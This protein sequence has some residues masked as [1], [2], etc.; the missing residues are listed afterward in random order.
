MRRERLAAAEDV[1]RYGKYI[2]PD[3]CDRT[4]VVRPMRRRYNGI[5][6]YSPTS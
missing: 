6:M 3:F 2:V 1:E 5:W 4:A